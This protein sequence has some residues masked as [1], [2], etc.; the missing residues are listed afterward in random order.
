MAMNSRR[1]GIC[2]AFRLYFDVDF[3][4]DYLLPMYRDLRYFVRCILYIKDCWVSSEIFINH[5]L[6][7]FD[8]FRRRRPEQRRPTERE[9]VHSTSVRRP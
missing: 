3:D 9:F 6:G 7:G 8:R 2:A 4:I 5:G 1:G